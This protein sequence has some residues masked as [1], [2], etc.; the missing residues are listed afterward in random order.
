[1]IEP[2]LKKFASFV[3]KVAAGNSKLDW[4]YLKAVLIRA[5]G[6]TNGWVRSWALNQVVR[7]PVCLLND[8]YYV[9]CCLL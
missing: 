3:D 6:H 9:S 1:M 8:D 4:R 5:L 2:V 7:T